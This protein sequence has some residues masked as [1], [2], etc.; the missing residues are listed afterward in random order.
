MARTLELNEIIKKLGVLEKN[1]PKEIDKSTK[2]DIE[3]LKT[4]ISESFDENASNTVLRGYYLMG[5]G[6][7]YNE[8]T[9][10]IEGTYRKKWSKPRITDTIT[11]NGYDLLVF[12][13]DTKIL[14]YGLSPLVTP[15]PL[16]RWVNDSEEGYYNAHNS[17][18]KGNWYRA[19]ELSSGNTA[20]L[21]S[22]G[23]SGSRFFARDSVPTMFVRK[24][25]EKYKNAVK[26]ND[27][28]VKLCA[29]G[30]KTIIEKELS[31]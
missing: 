10:A 19:I 31:K 11:N 4:K 27:A 3:Y 15:A 30:V 7:V 5:K 12:G 28:S 13:T 6:S 29:N 22:Y 9:I 14:E 25:V 8:N 16:L 21:V 24:G 2:E 26:S 18:G 17:Y 1:L 20:P 23:E